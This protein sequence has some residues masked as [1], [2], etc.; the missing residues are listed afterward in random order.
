MRR[1]LSPQSAL[2]SDTNAQQEP[3][4]IRAC[5][6]LCSLSAGADEVSK[7]VR[8]SCS[9]ARRRNSGGGRGS[10]RSCT[11]AHVAAVDGCAACCA[12][13]GKKRWAVAAAAFI[14]PR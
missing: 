4:L 7:Q 14:Q 1:R 8:W 9:G 12:G 13:G 2:Q 11:A 3:V 10:G 6:N 5:A